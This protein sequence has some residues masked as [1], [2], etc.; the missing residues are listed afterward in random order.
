MTYENEKIT[1]THP[2][3]VLR[4]TV[5]DIVTY[6]LRVYNEGDIAGFAQEI[7]DDI[8]E[9]LEFLPEHAT[10]REYKWVMYDKDG[11]STTKVS[12]AVKI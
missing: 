1:Y 10:N 3:D 4:T 2:K 6:T 9:Y 11:N 5:G 7:T 8:P 12:E